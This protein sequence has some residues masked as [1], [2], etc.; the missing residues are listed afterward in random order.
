MGN[1]GKNA[2]M[3][4]RQIERRRRKRLQ[5]RIFYVV[6]AVVFLIILV[7]IKNIY[8]RLEQIQ[9]VL[10]RLDTRQQGTSEPYGADGG[11]GTLQGQITPAVS[12]M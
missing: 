10:N 5:K 12:L 8:A 6:L 11:G 9:A 7:S 4:R 1:N 3:S 2:R